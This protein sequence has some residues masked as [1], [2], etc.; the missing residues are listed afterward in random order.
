MDVKKERKIDSYIHFFPSSVEEL[1]AWLVE[2]HEQLEGAWIVFGKKGSPHSKIAYPDFVDELLCFGWIDA[3]VRPIDDDTYKQLITP[4]KPKSVWSRVNKNKIEK[5]ALQGRIY[6]MGEAIIEVAKANG[7]WTI[8]DG[9]EN[10]EI[11]D[12]LRAELSKTEGLLARFE[13]L[14]RSRRRVYLQNL[15]FAKTQKTRDA[16]IASIIAEL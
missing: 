6:P 10:L 1:R 7:Y 15:L 11:P 2:N 13:S 5:L 3:V 8:L 9:V 12:D 14:S 16:R 4:R